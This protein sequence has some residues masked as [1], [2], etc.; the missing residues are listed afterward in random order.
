[1]IRAESTRI[2]AGNRGFEHFNLVFHI[3]ALISTL[4]NKIQ[5]ITFKLLCKSIPSKTIYKLAC[6]SFRNTTAVARKKANEKLFLFTSIQ[7][8][9]HQAS[10]SWKR[11]N[12]IMSR[13]LMK[14]YETLWQYLYTHRSTSSSHF[15]LHALSSCQKIILYQNLCLT[16]L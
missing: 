7:K 5:S 13:N 2:H 10:S 8:Q 6:S 3:L 11:L 14:Q 16:S 12:W 4:S 9:Q 15:C 1:M